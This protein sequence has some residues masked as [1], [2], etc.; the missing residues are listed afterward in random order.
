MAPTSLALLAL[1]A[2]ATPKLPPVSE[3]YPVVYEDATS[4]SLAAVA[5][6]MKE[7]RALEATAE[8][9]AGLRLPRKLTLKAASCGEPNAWYDADTDVVT[10]CYELADEFIRGAQAPE[11]FGLTPEQAAVA[12]F[13]F[14]MLHETAHAV[15]A[16][17]D[18]PVLGREEDAADQ[19]ATL[20][21]IKIGGTFAE[22]MLKGAA[23]MYERDS[24]ARKVGEE[25]FADMHGLDRQRYYNVLCLAWGAD[26][27]RFAFAQELGHLPQERAEGC[28]DEFKQ[29]RSAVQRLIVG[30]VDQTEAKRVKEKASRSKFAR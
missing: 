12:P 1:L 25:D 9:L 27:K 16:I 19:V 6:R 8:M 18:V 5:A 22:R 4:P 7:R 11:R 14:I 20:A 13:L 26:P 2:G 21:A 17:L 23:L 28:A 15:F 10:F 24:K 3:R 30:N 29:V